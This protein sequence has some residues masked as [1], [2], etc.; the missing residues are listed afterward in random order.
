MAKQI[1]QNPVVILNS[2]TISANVAQ[3]T[4]NL[5]ADDIEVTNFTSTARE[6]IGGLKDGT[7]SMD[8][9]Q[10][11]A[12]S[13]IDSIVFPLVGG[14]AAIKVRPGGTAA[15][16]TANPE[17]QFNVLVTEY[18]PIDSAVGDLA[19]FSVSWPITGAVTRATA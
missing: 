1:I 19:T 14:T 7:F 11:Y 16:G 9:H 4:I 12:A 6:R 3:A 10:D 5:T 8:V 17:Y 18:N 13:A 15:I 2:G